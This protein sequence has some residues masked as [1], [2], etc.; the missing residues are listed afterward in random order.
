MGFINYIPLPITG[1]SSNPTSI[2][3][4][5]TNSLIVTNIMVCNYLNQDMR[6]NLKKHRAQS[7]PF[8]IFYIVNFEV[9][10]GQ[11]VDILEETNIKEIILEY[12]VTPS[13]SDSLI[14]YSNGYTQVFDCE[15]SYMQLNELPMS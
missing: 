4:A 3:T 7:T 8:E 14:C 10:A 12:N 9:K 15:I 5:T 11:S 13:I 2:L 1:L 6:F